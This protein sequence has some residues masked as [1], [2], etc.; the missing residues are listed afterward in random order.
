MFSRKKK[1]TTDL[2]MNRI[3][4]LWI[5]LNSAL[6]P[7]LVFVYWASFPTEVAVY[8]EDFTLSWFNWE[9]NMIQIKQTKTPFLI[10]WL[11]YLLVSLTHDCSAYNRLCEELWWNIN[12]IITQCLCSLCQHRGGKS[13]AMIRA[14]FCHHHSD[15]SLGFNQNV[16]MIMYH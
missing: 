1:T 14:I 4:P 15:T 3:D 10:Q 9:R 7:F 6:N 11:K 5:L 8:H 12:T 13:S 2:E 16:V